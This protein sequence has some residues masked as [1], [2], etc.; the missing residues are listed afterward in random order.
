MRYCIIKDI[1]A[2]GNFS[3]A[4][5]SPL[6]AMKMSLCM[7]VKTTRAITLAPSEHFKTSERGHPMAFTRRRYSKLGVESKLYFPEFR[8]ENIIKE[9][10]NLVETTVPCLLVD[11]YA[12]FLGQIHRVTGFEKGFPVA[13]RQKDGQERDI[14]LTLSTCTLTRRFIN[15][16]K[17]VTG[18]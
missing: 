12:M 10:C 6:Y 1:S 17:G 9:G 16:Q 15:H 11:G 4:Q 14:A 3:K 18:A 13:F 8:R 2:T 5:I 7:L